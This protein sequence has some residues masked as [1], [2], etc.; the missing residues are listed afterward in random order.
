MQRDGGRGARQAVHL[1]SVIK[2]LEDIARP[3]CL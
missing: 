1:G 3:S 2:T